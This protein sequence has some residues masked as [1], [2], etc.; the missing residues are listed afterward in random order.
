ME[1]KSLTDEQLE[2]R[3]KD[4]T[5]KLNQAAR[6]NNQNMYQQIIAIQNTLQLEAQERSMRKAKEDKDDDNS[7]FDNLINVK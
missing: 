5:I 1:P 4:V 2:T 6:M 7:Q 3:L